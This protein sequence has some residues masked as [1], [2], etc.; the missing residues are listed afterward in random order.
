MQ[1][2]LTQPEPSYTLDAKVA[3][4]DAGEA[5]GE[6]TPDK[7]VLLGVLDTDMHLAGR[8]F[9][10]DVI[11]KT[12]S[13]DGH[14]KVTEAQLT[15]FDLIPKLAHLLQ[16]IGGLVGLTMPSGWEEQAFRTIEGDW[17]LL[18]GRI[19]TDHLQLRA[20]G[21]EALLTGSVG[22]DQSIDYTGNLFLPAQL[23]SRRGASILLRQDDAGHVI[24]PF[25]V[26]GMVGAP[27]I[28]LNEKA[29]IDPA[30][31][32]LVDT[33]RKRLG[34]KLEELFGQPPAADQ[35]S[36]ESDKTD[37]EPGDRAPGQRWPGKILQEL[38][39]R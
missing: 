10:W 22:L 26:K 20:E 39:R 18:Q 27:R 1:V 2:N 15:N 28:A 23:I 13:G 37:P 33:V 36:Q 8:G 4:L 19:L 6:L 14:V 16:N 17:R 30:K 38:F 12:L 11:S 29:L 3:G 31:E 34:G 21:M 25:T 7:N 9:T 5:L 24:V 32:E 35:P